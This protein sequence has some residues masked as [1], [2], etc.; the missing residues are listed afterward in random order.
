LPA[1]ILSLMISGAL[2]FRAI[3]KPLVLFE[4]LGNKP[5]KGNTQDTIFRREF[6]YFVEPVSS[7]SSTR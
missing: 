2:V 5:A 7:S 1:V 4:Q 6:T 3:P